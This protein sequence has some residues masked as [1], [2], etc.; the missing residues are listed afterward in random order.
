MEVA[1]N[2]E[3]FSDCVPVQFLHSK[4]RNLGALFEVIRNAIGSESAVSQTLPKQS[5]NLCKQ[6]LQTPSGNS[7]CFKNA[8]VDSSLSEK[9]SRKSLRSAVGSGQK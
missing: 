3:L 9:A 5:I 8:R 7:P 6:L 2:L 4:N 1:Q